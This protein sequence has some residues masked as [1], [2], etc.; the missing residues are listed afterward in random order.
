VFAAVLALAGSFSYAVL[1]GLIAADAG[2]RVRRRALAI[3]ATAPFAAI[4]IGIV[5]AALGFASLLVL[6]LVL[7]P[8]ALA[9]VAAGA[10]DAA[11][12]GALRAGVVL[13]FGSFRR[14]V[15]LA[16]I[17]ELLGVLLWLGLYIALS[18]LAEGLRAGTAAVVWGA[19]FGPLSALVFRAHYGA[20]TGRLVLARDPG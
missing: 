11:G 7:T 9:A 14:S 10:G 15:A 18:P 8:C 1:I 4:P 12:P 3:V 13:A 2:R 17:V 19:I 6:P 20:V 16:A 5:A